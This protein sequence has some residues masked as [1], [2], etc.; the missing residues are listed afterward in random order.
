MKKTTF[1]ILLV[2][3]VA[4]II[5]S[6]IGVCQGKVGA[7]IPLPACIAAVGYH[8]ALYVTSKNLNWC[9]DYTKSLEDENEELKK[10]ISAKDEAISSYKWEIESLKRK[11]R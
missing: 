1:W 7:L 9:A 5:V 10:A 8:L 3:L 4:T 2:I 6:I 11:I